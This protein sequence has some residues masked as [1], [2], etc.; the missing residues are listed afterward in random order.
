MSAVPARGEPDPG[1]P[2]KNREGAQEPGALEK[3]RG[4]GG[5]DEPPA[6]P[7]TLRR[8]G[9]LGP[10]CHSGPGHSPGATVGEDGGS[11]AGATAGEERA[12]GRWHRAGL[13]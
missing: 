11:V 5:E 4:G 3:P 10:R 12:A 9:V 2:G 13:T 8:P 1:L 6:H 7:T